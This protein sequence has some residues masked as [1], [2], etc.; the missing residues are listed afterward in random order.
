M[1]C[2]IILPAS[3]YSLTKR[4]QRQQ[5]LFRGPGCELRQHLDEFVHHRTEVTLQLLPPLLHKLGILQTQRAPMNNTQSWDTLLPRVSGHARRGAHL[6]AGISRSLA[7]VEGQP[8]A[9]TLT[10]GERAALAAPS[11]VAGARVANRCP[12]RLRT[13]AWQRTVVFCD[14]G[15]GRYS[16]CRTPTCSRI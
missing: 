8:D 9:V 1:S 2:V 11:H 4:Q 14:A 7:G 6:P 10:F 16:H 3:F 5:G 13:K 15:T 12:A